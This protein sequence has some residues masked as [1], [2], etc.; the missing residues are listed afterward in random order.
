MASLS[1]ELLKLFVW[2][3]TSTRFYP[4]GLVSFIM[5]KQISASVIEL[6]ADV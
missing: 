3:M 4:V 6:E 5:I 1:L 2:E